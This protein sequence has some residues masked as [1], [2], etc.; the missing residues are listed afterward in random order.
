M[1]LDLRS[2]NERCVTNPV[3]SFFYSCS[4]DQFLGLP[5]RPFLN[6]GARFF[7]YYFNLVSAVV[8]GH[9]DIKLVGERQWAWLEAAVRE[10]FEDGEAEVGGKWPWLEAAAREIFAAERRREVSSKIPPRMS[11]RPRGRF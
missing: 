9:P 3:L 1:A 7:Q 4:N 5:L 8:W 6:A 11:A 2:F 10:I